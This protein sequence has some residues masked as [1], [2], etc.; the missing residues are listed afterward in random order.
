MTAILLNFIVNSYDY[1]NILI[2]SVQLLT[3][4]KLYIIQLNVYIYVN[5]Y[6]SE[7]SVYNPFFHKLWIWLIGY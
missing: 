5:P 2:I 7:M 3:K 6:L 1:I 4:Y